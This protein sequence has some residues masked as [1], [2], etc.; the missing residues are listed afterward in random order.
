MLASSGTLGSATTNPVAVAAAPATRL[1]ISAQPAF[2]VI[3][4]NDFTIV[5]TAQDGFGN[6]DP[7]FLGTVAI[8]L[9]SNGGDPLAGHSAVTAVAGVARFVDL[10]LQ[11]VASG[12]TLRVSSGALT[13]AITGVIPVVAAEATHLVVTTAPPPS[14]TAGDG[15]NL[16][17]L[18]E[19]QFGN[20]DSTFSGLVTLR[21]ADNPP[22][23]ILG[24]TFS[25]SATAGV[26]SFSG[27]TLEQ[28]GAGITLAASSPGLAEARTD[29]I[30]VS[31][32][33]A[34]QLVVT[35]QPMSL[36]TAG[37]PLGLVIEATDRFGNRDPGFTGTVTLALA[38][39]PGHDSLGGTLALPAG[40]GLATFNDLILTKAAS[41]VTLAA[42]SDGL[43]GT[44]THSFDVAAAPAAQLVVSTQP[45]DSVTAGNGFGLIVEAR[46]GF[47]NL[48]PNFTGTI[49][50][51]LVKNAGDAALGGVL[52]LAARS[53]VATFSGLAL[54]R[55]G[56]AYSIQ[57]TSDGGQSGTLT[58]PIVVNAA[59]ATQLVVTAQPPATV[60]AGNTFGLAVAIEDAFGNV[61]FDA[62]SSVTLALADNPRGDVLGS[63]PAAPAR[64]GVATFTGLSLSRSAAAVSLVASSGGLGSTFT[65]V[66]AVA[67]GAATHLAFSSP[68]SAAVTAGMGFAVAVAAEDQFGNVDMS[69]SGS[70]TLTLLANPGTAILGGGLTAPTTAGV[71]TLASLTL[72]TA[73]TGYVLHASSDGLEG[74][75]SADIT[76]APA[77]AT[78]LVILSQPPVS[79][80]AGSAFSVV[81]AAEDLLGNIDPN[82]G[83]PVTLILAG[84]PGG[85]ALGGSLQL[86]ASHGSVSF[87]D[88]TL[89]RGG[90]GYSLEVTGEALQGVL[91]S[92]IAVI[93]PPVT[94]NSVSV[95]NRKLPKRKT[96]AL[97]V[98]QF[99]GAL[100]PASA[101][102]VGAFTLTTAAQGK[103]R[104][105]KLVALAKSSYNAA[106]HTVTLT[107]L[108]Q[109]VLSPP[110]ELQVNASA[111]TDTFG[112]PL[113]GDR[114]G[115][116]GG[117]VQAT[118]SKG[119]I[120]LQSTER[121]SLFRPMGSIDAKPEKPRPR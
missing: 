93:P 117:N 20:R 31:P 67:A 82:Y 100:D 49:S 8:A 56:T 6:I 24:G 112:R 45:P 105:G 116:P 66:F 106:T 110:L 28:A 15:F 9:D 1:V 71:A 102:S 63:D 81:I 98:L 3:A 48:D 62:T 90:S 46:D 50:L 83:G 86:T 85:A 73:G 44:T 43:T 70:V 109:L 120:S 26:A 54:E 38:N 87:T 95:Q 47:G 72:Y 115:H 91:S 10:E 2:G 22:G 79:V 13:S 37:T 92:R 80:G 35:A 40:D 99:D 108:K 51:T 5:A 21:L 60:T 11:K 64:A 4:G 88:L 30:S 59:A 14:I 55:A 74:A 96:Q 39:N 77:A 103:K 53:G 107:P 58:E 18:A 42:T 57:V 25:L 12:D 84:N 33:A 69:Y 113:D 118:L 65:S 41:G 68:P 19:D 97:I 76:V 61:V 78:H 114:D 7:S 101:G 119:R 121:S 32:A 52:A 17:A 36:A 27:L 75:T 34:T 29:L 89:D 16:I 94:L 111:L 104:G 23:A